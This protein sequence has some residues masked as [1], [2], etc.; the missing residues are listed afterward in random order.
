MRHVRR[1]ASRFTFCVSVRLHSAA[2]VMRRYSF[3]HSLRRL[4]MIIVARTADAN[5]NGVEAISST[6]RV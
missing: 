6:R 2:L 1:M 3:I 5:A 4:S